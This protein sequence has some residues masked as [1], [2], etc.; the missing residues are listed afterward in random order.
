MCVYGVVCQRMKTGGNDQCVCVC[1]C[2]CAHIF[3]LLSNRCPENADTF[4]PKVSLICR[5]AGPRLKAM[6]S[7]IIVCVSVCVSVCV[8][9]CV[10][11]SVCMWACNAPRSDSV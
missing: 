10:Y 11:V 2:V 1:V 3:T 6:T 8:C 5:G 4:D 7:A 9:V